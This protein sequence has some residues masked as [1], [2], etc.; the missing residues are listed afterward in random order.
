MFL[1]HDNEGQGTRHIVK[2]G[3]THCQ[4]NVEDLTK[5]NANLTKQQIRQVWQNGWLCSICG[6]GWQNPKVKWGKHWEDEFPVDDD[7][8][9][10]R[11]SSEAFEKAYFGCNG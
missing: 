3:I 5:G 1:Y 6:E 9:E 8:N 4:R 10:L 7:K 2:N 11:M